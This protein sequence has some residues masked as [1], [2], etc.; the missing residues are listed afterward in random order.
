MG[1]FTKRSAAVVAGSVLAVAGGTAAFAYAQG[2]FSGNGSVTATASTIQ[3]VTA[4]VNLGATDA[5]RLYPGKSVPIS[6]VTVTNPNDYPVLITGISVAGVS[7]TNKP[8]CATGEANLSFAPVPA[9]T[10]LNAGQGTTVNLGSISMGQNANPVCSGAVLTVSA[11]L[12]G[13]I[14]PH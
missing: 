2:W 4:T 11:N 8:G 14:A 5:T 10:T 9:G 12:E 6:N 3:T 13:E 1:N 7:S